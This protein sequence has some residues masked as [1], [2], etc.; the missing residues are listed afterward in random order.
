MSA[1]IVDFDALR[2]AIRHME[3]F[4]R[5]VGECLD[6]IEHTMAMLRGSW[7]GAASDAQ[8]QAQKQWETG[9]EQMKES[10]AALQKV[11]D[12][13]HKNYTDAVAKN[14]QMWQA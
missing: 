12:T 8:A 3:E 4:G 9:A 13:A 10:L 2:A 5:E 11:A 7:E 6:D 14:G 1:L